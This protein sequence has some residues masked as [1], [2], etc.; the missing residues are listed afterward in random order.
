MSKRL[1]IVTNS[2]SNLLNFRGELIKK[3][4]NENF[5][6]L[7]IIPKKIFQLILKTRVLKLGAKSFKTIPLDRAG[8]NPFHD[9]FNFLSLKI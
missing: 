8:I 4:V 3:L 5:E 9:F 1:I 7:V 6:V 2:S